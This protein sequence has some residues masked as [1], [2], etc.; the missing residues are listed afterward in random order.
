MA[1]LLSYSATFEQ[2]SLAGAAVARY[3]LDEGSGRDAL[4]SVAGLDGTYQTGAAPGAAG[5]IGDGAGAFDGDSG[6]V[7]VDTESDPSVNDALLLGSG[8]FEMWF[9]ID[10]LGQQQTLFAKDSAGRGDGGQVA[11]IVTTSGRLIFALSDETDVFTAQSDGGVVKAGAATH[12]V[13][14]FGDGG[15]H[16]FVDGVEVA[17]KGYSGGLDAG[18]GNSEQL[19][20]GAGNGTSETGT[21]D[22][23]NQFVN[24]TIDEFAIYDRTLSDDQ[25]QQLFDGGE[26]GNVI[27]GTAQADVLIGG[28]DDEVLRGRGG[29]DVILGGPGND[30]LIGGAG[31]DQLRGGGGDDQLDGKGGIDV[32]AGGGGN[33]LL[34]GSRGDDLLSGGG[35]SDDLQGNK[36]A[37]VLRGGGGGDLLN[38]G[39]GNDTLIGGGGSDTFRI[40]SVRD[41][42]DQIRDFAAGEG[43]DILDLSAVLDFQ[44]GDDAAG[45]VQLDE[46]NGNTNVAVDPN[47]GGDAFT[48]V[49]NLVG[50][51]GLDVGSLVA[52]GN[53]QLTS[54]PS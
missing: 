5:F 1:T 53:L 40:D 49:F 15:M 7:L 28:S 4:D 29:D 46:V 44:A 17:N 2:T 11:M 48:T 24:G 21:I 39:I 14:N 41:G 52:D 26:F 6:F 31:D 32:L 22:N 25:I 37:D 50:A 30:G 20:I 47:G 33:D 35:G 45:F 3:R 36:G 38:G 9:Q 16:V 51:T 54:T 8:A 23:V 42:V 27:V 19:V 43:G 34:A 13:A 12:L 18:L 10:D